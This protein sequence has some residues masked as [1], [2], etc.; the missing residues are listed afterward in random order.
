[1]KAYIIRVNT[2]DNL[3]ADYIVEANNLVSA[4]FKTKK[5]FLKD[6]S[7]ADPKI[8]LQLQNPTDKTIKEIIEIIKGGK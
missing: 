5:A 3:Y 7:D 4:R 6:Y 2:I 1:M 8:K